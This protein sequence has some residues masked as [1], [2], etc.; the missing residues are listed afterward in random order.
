[1]IIGKPVQYIVDYDV[2]TIGREF[3]RIQFKGEDVIT[4][5]VTEGF[6]RTRL[7]SGQQRTPYAASHLVAESAR[8]V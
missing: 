2:P 8:Q 5:L 6:L 7:S 4:R 1:M 3:G